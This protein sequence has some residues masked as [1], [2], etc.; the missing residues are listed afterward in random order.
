MRA[1]ALVVIAA[2]GAS[3]P[4][5]PLVSIE[6]HAQPRQASESAGIPPGYVEAKVM[7]VLAVA[8]GNGAVL[9]V[10][11]T[12]TLVLPIFIGGTEAIS[13]D[14]RMRGQARPRPLTHDLYDATVRKL[15]GK[16]VK[17]HV[18]KLENET[19]HGSVFVRIGGRIIKL[20]ARPSDALALAIGNKLPIYVAKQVFEQAGVDKQEILKQ[21]VPPGG[22]EA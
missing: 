10:D 8:E 11:E 15:G 14:A 3:A 9:L 16:L 17:V 1:V 7:Q 18:D 4:P 5:P 6:R 21:L 19:F 2:C 22:S 20:D 13:I 12:D